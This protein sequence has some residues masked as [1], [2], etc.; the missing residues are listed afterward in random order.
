MTAFIIESYKALSEDPTETSAQMLKQISMQI[1]LFMASVNNGTANP[2]VPQLP[3]VASTFQAPRSAVRVNV[4][5]FTSLILSLV[6]ASL[7]ILVKSWLHGYLAS[8]HTSPKMRLRVRFFR[9]LGLHEWGVFEIAALLPLLIQVALG[10]FFVGL[11]FFTFSVDSRVGIASI[12]VVSMWALLVVVSIAL[13]IFASRCPYRIPLPGN[14]FTWI[15]RNV[16]F[17]RLNKAFNPSDQPLPSYQLMQREYKSHIKLWMEEDAVA[18]APWLDHHI[19]V[20][21]DHIQADDQLL[22][23]SIIQ[24]YKQTSP[25]RDSVIP[26]ALRFLQARN[27]IK[28]DHWNHPQVPVLPQTSTQ[29]WQTLSTLIAD[30]IAE[31]IVTQHG[32]TTLSEA[33]ASLVVWRPWMIDGI[34]L[35]VCNA[36]LPRPSTWVRVLSL[37]TPKDFCRLLCTLPDD[38]F[39]DSLHREQRFIA[40]WETHEFLE[41]PDILQRL[42]ELFLVAYRPELQGNTNTLLGILHE[43]N[44]KL[45]NELGR[46]ITDALFRRISNAMANNGGE[47]WLPEAVAVT[48]CLFKSASKHTRR[49]LMQ[50]KWLL[51]VSVSIPVLE[52]IFRA[53]SKRSQDV[54][55]AFTSS[56][57]LANMDG[58]WESHVYTTDS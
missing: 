58:M 38:L 4:L 55:N 52:E 26:F 14:L 16:I 23:T 33:E 11:C 49:Q 43:A 21:V 15:R 1:S 42:R 25:P 29:L 13:P 48:V 12:V 40:L 32:E 47:E 27:L 57:Q 20:G 22:A 6:T 18:Q 50:P 54:M 7:G 39:E 44:V 41:V 10:L 2:I 30:T 19:I 36:H 8:D 53:R 37:C 34:L 28:P 3:D 45:Y 56:Y 24:S 9:Y 51:H 35:I 31:E 5:W 17:R 46:T